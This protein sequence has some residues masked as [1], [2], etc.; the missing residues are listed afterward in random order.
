MI[1]VIPVLNEAMN[2]LPTERKAVGTI[3]LFTALTLACVAIPAGG[4]LAPGVDEGSVI[5]WAV[6][7]GVLAA[8]VAGVLVFGTYRLLGFRAVAWGAAFLAGAFLGLFLGYCLIF[9]LDA[10]GFLLSPLLGVLNAV[11]RPFARKPKA[12]LPAEPLKPG[13]WRRRN[14][15]EAGPTG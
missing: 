5:L 7:G 14:W 2:G 10:W 9:L 4:F 11:F 1:E 8:V 6:G 12:K 3:A 13:E 15:D